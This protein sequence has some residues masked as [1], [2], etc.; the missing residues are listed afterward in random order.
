MLNDRIGRDFVNGRFRDRQIRLVAHQLGCICLT[1]E[2]DQERSH[3]QQLKMQGQFDAGCRFAGAA[4]DHIHGDDDRANAWGQSLQVAL[5]PTPSRKLEECLWLEDPN[6]RGA[7]FQVVC[8]PDGDAR[9]V[10]IAAHRVVRDAEQR[11]CRS[12]TVH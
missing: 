6:C 10:R 7:S 8:T 5:G 4:F 12:E 9:T 2:V 3:P 11:S 1:I